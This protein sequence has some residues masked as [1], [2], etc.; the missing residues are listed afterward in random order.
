MSSISALGSERFSTAKPDVRWAQVGESK[1]S[2]LDQSRRFVGLAA[3]LLNRVV[4]NVWGLLACKCIIL[5]V[6]AFDIYLTVKYVEFLPEMELNPVGRW[7]LG[8]DNGPR[9]E[10]QHAAA[11]IT[12]K[13]AGNVVVLGIIETLAHCGFRRIGYV[14]AAV[15]LFQVWLGAFLC[16]ADFT[17]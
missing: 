10:L 4:G 8:I 12:A 7:L 5:A 1:V 3:E 6:S 11:F 15:A 9:C 2:W 14:A 17:D 13:F 16:C